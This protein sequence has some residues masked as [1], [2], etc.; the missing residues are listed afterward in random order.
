[1]TTFHCG[2]EADV[3]DAVAAR[4]WPERADAALRDHAAACGVC[5]DAAEIALAFRQDREADAPAAVPP[6]SVVWWK[7]QV[8]AREDSARLALRP[9]VL[10]QTAAT[11]TAAAASLALAPAAAAWVRNGLTSLGGGWSSVPESLGLSWVLSAAAYTTLP[12]L[13]VGAW[14]VL[15]PVVVYLALDE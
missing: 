10:V 12:L 9:I 7:A 1:M 6:S 14:V 3:L 11:M 13:A 8:R 2:H 4:R 5:A 15:A